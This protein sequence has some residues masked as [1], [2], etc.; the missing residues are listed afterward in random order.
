MTTQPRKPDYFFHVEGVT[1]PEDLRDT[2]IEQSKIEN[3]SPDMSDAINPEIVFRFDKT[4]SIEDVLY[5]INKIDSCPAMEGTSYVANFHTPELKTLWDM[6]HPEAQEH[7]AYIILQG[8]QPYGFMC[9]HK[10]WEHFKE[11]RKA[12]M[13]LPLTP[14]DADEWA[15]LEYY[16]EAGHTKVAEVEWSPC[17][18]ADT[19]KVHG[20][21]N[22]GNY[23]ASAAIAFDCGEATIYTLHQQGKLMA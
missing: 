21:E 3:V 9:P 23:R 22:N 6:I 17:Y 1:L 11:I 7:I 12:V 10:D 5:T 4:R 18:V 16:N 14:Y 2:L 20:Y 15:P 19:Q 13:F 8:S